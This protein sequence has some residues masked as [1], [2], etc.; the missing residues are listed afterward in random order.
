[1]LLVTIVIRQLIPP[2][3]LDFANDSKVVGS[4]APVLLRGV[5]DSVNPGRGHLASTLRIFGRWAAEAFLGEIGIVC[6][7]VASTGIV[8]RD[9]LPY[10]LPLVD[11]HAMATVE[12]EDALELVAMINAI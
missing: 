6:A 9:G 3:D 7:V 4:G 1:M 12:R 8:L 2:A 10:T 11:L 5:D